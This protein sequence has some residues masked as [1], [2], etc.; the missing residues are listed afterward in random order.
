MSG[1]RVILAQSGMTF[2]TGARRSF[3]TDWTN[4]VNL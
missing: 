3:M 4:L 2:C 1:W